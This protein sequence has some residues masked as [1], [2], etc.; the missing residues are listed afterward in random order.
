VTIGEAMEDGEE[1]VFAAR[2]EGDDV[3]AFGHGHA[4]CRLEIVLELLIEPEMIVWK[5]DM[6]IV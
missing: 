3:Q 1:G 2:D 5:D 6:L 4:A